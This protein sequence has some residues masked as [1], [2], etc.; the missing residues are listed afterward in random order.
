MSYTSLL[1]STKI[2]VRSSNSPG[3]V[4]HNGVSLGEL[5]ELDSN[6]V[7][8]YVYYHH[9]IAI[10][11]APPP[12][13]KAM[14][15]PPNVLL[16]VISYYNPNTKKV[17]NNLLQ[18]PLNFEQE[19]TVDGTILLHDVT[20]GAGFEGITNIITHIPSAGGKRRKRNTYKKR[21]ARRRKT[22]YHRR[23]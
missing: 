20:N 17:A 10:L 12:K 8:R 7:A 18:Y 4:L 23:R 16:A 9:G 15:Q 11:Y 3:K 21:Y 14:E 2:L 6:R 1:P 5:Q 22:Q 13:A 19:Y